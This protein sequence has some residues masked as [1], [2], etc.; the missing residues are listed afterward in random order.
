ML[1]LLPPQFAILAG[2][3]SV[4]GG[5]YLSFVPPDFRP[6]GCRQYEDSKPPP[7]QVLLVAQVLVGSNEQV[8][9][10]LGLVEEVPVGKVGPAQFVGRG[11]GM[12]A[13]RPPPWGGRP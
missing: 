11:H 8:K 12:A 1:S 3:N 13:Q 4:H 9:L 10:G 6:M 7:G 2:L 5:Q